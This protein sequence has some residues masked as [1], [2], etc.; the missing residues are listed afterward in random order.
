LL[1]E[2]Y[3]TSVVPGSYFELPAHFRVGLGGDTETLAAGLKR[4]GSALDELS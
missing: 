1:R 4:L 3:E 2:K